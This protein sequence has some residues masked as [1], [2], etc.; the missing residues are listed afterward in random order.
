M[1][2]RVID[3]LPLKIDLETPVIL[4]KTIIAKTA[5]RISTMT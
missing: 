2:N 5:V 3:L 1:K 4:K